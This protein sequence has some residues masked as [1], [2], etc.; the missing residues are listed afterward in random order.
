MVDGYVDCI[1]MSNQV[2]DDLDIYQEM[3]NQNWRQHQMDD[4]ITKLFLRAVTNKS[5]LDVSTFEGSEA[6]ALLKEFNR[7][8]VRRGVCIVIFLRMVSTNFS[9]YCQYSFVL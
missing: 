3:D 4:P 6:K 8:V 7:F 2:L 9:W 5:K 1:R